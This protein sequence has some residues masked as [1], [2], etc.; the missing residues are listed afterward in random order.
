MDSN[1]RSPLRIYRGKKLG[2]ARRKSSVKPR[3][4][5][6][7]DTKKKKKEKEKKRE[8]G[9]GASGVKPAREVKGGRNRARARAE[10]AHAA[11]QETPG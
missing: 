11:A 8:R 5:P 4:A 2:I 6:V 1:R 7:A 3:R 10:I 9:K